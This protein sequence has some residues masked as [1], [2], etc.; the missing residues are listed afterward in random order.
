MT[1]VLPFP[2]MSVSVLVMWLVLNQTVSP[3]HILLGGVVGLVAGWALAKL[4]PS[5]ERVRHLGAVCRL[6]SLVL[7]DIAKSNLAVA[8]LILGL[9]RRR[10]V[11]GFVKI[12]LELRHPSGLAALACIITSTPGTVWVDFD[13][14][15]RVLTIH[16]LDLVDENQWVRIVKDRYER[17]LLEI[18]A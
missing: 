9:E 17:L 3:G 7:L 6:F 10:G 15:P 2:L 4:Q 1:R 5:K 18:F 11:S 14:V 13:P 12:P 8:R 16:V